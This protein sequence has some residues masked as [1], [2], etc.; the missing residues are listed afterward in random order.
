MNRQMHT[1]EQEDVMAYLD[2]ELAPE[3]AA[4]MAGHLRECASCAGLAK[5]L[6]DVSQQMLAWEV[7]VSPARLERRVTE[8]A[9]AN[10]KRGDASAKQK[11]F[12]SD[13]R[14][15][16]WPWQ[17]WAWALSAA[18]A[19]ALA[20]WGFSGTPLLRLAAPE[21]RDS[22]REMIGY[23]APASPIAPSKDK[24]FSVAEGRGV[25][26]ALVGGAGSGKVAEA[27]GGPM[28]ARTTR[29]TIVIRDFVDARRRME[30]ILRKYDGYA[31]ELTVSTPA[32]GARELSATLRIPAAQLEAAL[33][34]LRALGRVE[35]ESQL[36][37]EVTKQYVDLVARLNNA[38]ATER[39][40]LDILR[41]RTGKVS[42]VLEVEREVSR[43]REEIE[44]MDAERKAL[45]K[46]VALATVELKLT[47]EYKAQLQGPSA[48]VG[49][50]MRNAVVNGLRSAADGAIGIVLFFLGYGPSLLLWALILFWPARV[51]WRRARA[52]FAAR[53]QSIHAT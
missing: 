52:A 2:G 46:R 5:E 44:Q 35:Q 17:R 1:V 21:H 13:V 30:E 23:T 40:L 27:E 51:L 31:G 3:Q 33:V 37:E 53:Q 49:T 29:L 18:G 38:R 47:E 10:A 22:P 32:G 19:V 50:Q 6:S 26:G 11:R 42:E 45:E 4:A 7:E 48:S 24:A 14:R 28:I 36:A 25:A 39:R 8:A 16:P 41:Q 12:G 15:Q 20:L 43:V 34:E 9:E